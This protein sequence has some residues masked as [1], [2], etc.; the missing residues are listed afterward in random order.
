MNTDSHPH[1]DAVIIGAGF[2]GMYAIYKLRKIGLSVRAF[3][4]GTDVGGT[5]YW[6]RYPGARCD[7]ESIEYSYSFSDALQQEW[8][9]SERYASQP[10]ILRYASH[11]ADR[12]D[13]RDDIRFTQRV[14]SAEFDPSVNRWTVRTDKGDTVTAQFLITAAGCLSVPRMPDIPGR[15]EFNGKLY[16][17]GAWPHEGVDFT[18]LHVGVIGTGS[19]GI[20]AIPQIA[21]AAAHCTVFQRTPNFSL[22]AYN[23]P[24]E[25]QFEREYKLN[26]A[27]HR[28]KARHS[29]AGIASHPTPEK[30]AFDDSPEDRERV[31]ENGWNWGNTGFTR[32][33]KDIL[34]STEANDTMADFV[35]RKIRDTVKNPEVAAMLTP[36]DHPIG[37]KRICLDSDYFETYNRDNVTL[38]DVRKDSIV[39]LSKEGVVTTNSTYALDAIVFATGYD[40][41]T[42]A[43]LGIDIRVKGRT[44][45]LAQ[46]WRAGPRT[47][48]GLMTAG[49]P[50]LFFITGPGSPSVLT[51]MISS[52]EQHV[53]W[54]AEC[55]QYLR[56]GGLKRMEARLDSEDAWV[57]HVNEVADSTL[58]PRAASWYMGA[59]IPG[60]P[61][62]F[63]PY[64]GGL[65]RYRAKCDEV[66]SRGYEGFSLDSAVL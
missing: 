59:N 39:K 15:D 29:S 49:F 43:I 24:M 18:G 50:N 57:A 42:G 5:W 14:L 46:K 2:G 22:A 37:T 34:S 16:H 12:F 32:I 13:L 60:K 36:T 19:S 58:F 30:G 41:V 66:A 47:Y 52:I 3:E 23:R 63:L 4:A 62:V 25:A 1:F 64:V 51:N 40:A 9:W 31:Y 17:T 10:E 44:E 35:R 45:S 21:K 56:A 55:L 65:G 53:E 7:V 54:I 8:S 11:V 26:Y 28:A 61:R 27:K 6:N 38:V 20:Q 33:Y 48:L